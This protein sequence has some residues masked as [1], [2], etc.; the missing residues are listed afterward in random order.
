MAKSN[1]RRTQPLAPGRRNL[2]ARKEGAVGLIAI[3][4]QGIDLMPAIDEMRAINVDPG[5]TIKSACFLRGRSEIFP[6]KMRSSRTGHWNDC[7]T[8]REV[9]VATSEG[10]ASSENDTNSPVSMYFADEMLDLV[11]DVL[12]TVAGKGECTSLSARA[13]LDSLARCAP[14]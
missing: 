6:S 4:S 13:S 14:G 9:L 3:I 11:G 1:R 7:E 2:G 12:R 10:S 8:I 5:T